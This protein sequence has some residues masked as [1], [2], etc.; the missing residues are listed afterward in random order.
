MHNILCQYFVVLIRGVNG[1][2][3]I[4][5]REHIFGPSEKNLQTGYLKTMLSPYFDNGIRLQTLQKLKFTLYFTIVIT[6]NIHIL[7]NLATKSY[8]FSW[9]PW[10]LH[11]TQSD[12]LVLTSRKW[13]SDTRTRGDYVQMS[14]RE[15]KSVPV[16]PLLYNI[17]CLSP[18]G[19]M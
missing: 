14:N 11:Y 5:L 16:T 7:K 8:V 18:Q 3:V 17:V 6:L 2:P 19:K 4:E 12:I 13:I 10:C 1:Y 9:K 15:E